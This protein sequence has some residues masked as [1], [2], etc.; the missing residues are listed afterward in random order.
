MLTATFPTGRARVRAFGVW[1]ATNAA[2]GALGVLI[3]GVLTQYASWRWV[4]FISVPM[5]AVALAMTWYG[6][7]ADRP[8]TPTARPD[9]L[10]AVL[11][12]GGMSLL[13]F[14]IVRT[15]R[16]PW[17]ST[18][19]LTTLAAAVAVLT[20]FVLV[21]R[22]TTREPLIRP[23]LLANRAV[24]GANTYNLLLGAA[25]AAS[26]YFASLYLQRI[27]GIEPARA[28]T[29]FLPFAVGIGI[30]SVLAVKLGYRLPPRTLLIGGGLLTAAGFAWFGRISADGSF[31]TDILAPSIVTGIG[32]GFCL[33]PVV[34]MATAGA[35]PQE[36]GAASALLNSSRQIGA[37]LGLAALGTA[38]QHHTGPIPTPS[39]VTSGYAL[40]MSL[41]AALLLA[42][43]AIAI[44]V[45]PRTAPAT[46]TEPAESVV[47]PTD[48]K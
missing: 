24:A 43:V 30:G 39:A 9:V 16:H 33:G 36:S 7:V 13:V 46:S 40:G 35:P 10:G 6:I 8:L 11:A 1:A 42:A 31:L 22:R 12:T 28:G 4:M 14:G 23:G 44:T 21:E 29:M 47:Q 19:T 41:G 26:F 34:S 2:G 32:F 5:A 37:S 48:S 18:T 45:L 25:M 17:T 27:L 3:G 20:V 38:A 15:D